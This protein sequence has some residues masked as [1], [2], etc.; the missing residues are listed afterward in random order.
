MRS[1]SSSARLRVERV[2]QAV[3]K[4]VEGQSQNHD[5]HPRQNRRPWSPRS[6]LLGI[7]EHCPQTRC[8]WLDTETEEGEHGLAEDG[9]GD[10][11][12]RLYEDHRGRVRQDVPAEHPQ[13]TRPIDDRG[14]DE[15]ERLETKLSLIHISEPTR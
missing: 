13:V 4:N 6:E 8:G 15:V 10:R 7:G 5:R 11:H 9:G 12:G 2:A 3:T 14:R 1:K